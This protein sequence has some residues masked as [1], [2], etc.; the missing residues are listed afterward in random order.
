MTT[1]TPLPTEIGTQSTLPDAEDTD[2]TTRSTVTTAST[3]E[4]PR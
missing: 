2:G 1:Q 3:T 4:K